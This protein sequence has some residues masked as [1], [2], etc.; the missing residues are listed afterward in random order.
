MP[1]WH[2]RNAWCVSKSRASHDDA[3]RRVAAE[4]A[5]ELRRRR[6]EI[7]LS[8]EDVASR[9]GISRYVYQ[10]YEKGEGR[11]GRA[12]NPQLRTLISL[13]QALDTTVGALIPD[14]LPDFRTR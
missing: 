14:E 12:L 7:G 10:M 6:A 9:A 8:Q 4:F 5:T 11:P 1:V 3:W 2:S 13:A